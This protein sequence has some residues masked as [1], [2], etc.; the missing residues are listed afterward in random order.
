MPR[1]A[2]QSGNQAPRQRNVQRYWLVTSVPRGAVFAVQCSRSGSVPTLGQAEMRTV[3][4]A[5]GDLSA[6]AG[7]FPWQMPNVFLLSVWSMLQAPMAS[8]SCS[9]PAHAWWSGPCG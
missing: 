3:V 7:S 1:S 6:C 8:I 4:P 2:A 9:A 5:S